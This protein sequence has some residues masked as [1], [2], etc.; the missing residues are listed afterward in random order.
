[1]TPPLQAGEVALAA[2]VVTT[3]AATALAG[4]RRVE[5]PVWASVLAALV[6]RVAIAAFA[7]RYTPADVSHHFRL[8][9]EYVTHGRDPIALPH[10]QW[11]FLPLMAYVH[12]VELHLG[13]PWTY[14]VKVVPILTDCVT[15]WL[16]SLVATSEQRTRALQYALNPVS[17]LVVAVHGQVEPV[18]LCLAMAAVALY[19]RDRL[20]LAGLVAGAAVAAKTWPVLVVVALLRRDRRIVPFLATTAVVPLA[21]F[22]SGL[23]F[24]DTSLRGTWQGLTGYSSYVGAWTWSGTLIARGG[25]NLVGYGSPL[26]RPGTVLTIAA[27]AA[28]LVAFR[29]ADPATRVGVALATPLVVTAGFGVQYLMWPVPFLFAA[30]FPRRATYTA[31][32]GLWLLLFYAP[33]AF[34][35]HP[36]RDLYLTG[37][38]WAIVLVLAGTL[39]DKWRA[40]R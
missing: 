11:N 23:A 9:G 22:V 40:A 38:S 6:L 3:A 19:Q 5:I 7:A 31:T 17:L 34:P 28:A 24:L 20:A 21:T 12:A 26:G 37:A 13:L 18:A 4:H 2:T 25:K 29:H 15:V 1:M 39:R 33:H 36:T 14:A 32:A 30:G 27:V 8:T 16:V 35:D 10:H